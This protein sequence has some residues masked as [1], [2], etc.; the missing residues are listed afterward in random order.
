MAK[1]NCSQILSVETSFRSFQNSKK[2]G[3]PPNVLKPSTP[4]FGKW[5]AE[6]DERMRTGGGATSSGN[7]ATQEHAPGRGTTPRAP[8]RWV[9]PTRPPRVPIPPTSCVGH[10]FRCL[11]GHYPIRA[12]DSANRSSVYPSPERAIGVGPALDFFSL[13]SLLLLPPPVP[14][15]LSFS[16]A[17]RRRK[18]TAKP[19]ARIQSIPTVSRS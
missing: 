9:P 13:A 6:W 12:H 16:A 14:V 11:A 3:K 4:P 10:P 2:K 5:E 17:S 8:H 19:S 18:D 1:M 15:R 7:H